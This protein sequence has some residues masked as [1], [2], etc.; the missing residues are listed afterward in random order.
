MLPAALVLSLGVPVSL[1]AQAPGEVQAVAQAPA[2]QGSVWPSVIF[3]G[4]FK[5]SPDDRTHYLERYGVREGL[6]SDRRQSWFGDAGDLSLVYHDGLRD[7]VRIQRHVSSRY[8]QRGTARVDTSHIRVT[9]GYGYFQ[10]AASGLDYLFAPSQIEGAVDPRYTGGNVGYLGKFNDAVRDPLFAATRTTYNG[11]LTVKPAAFADKATVGVA[12]HGID[13]S[14]TAFSSL[15]TGGGDV[16]GTD[17]DRR[18]KLRWNGY[19]SIVD[20]STNELVF[21]AAVRPVKQLNMEYELGYER[22]RN[23]APAVDLGDVITASGIRIVSTTAEA[24]AEEP[25]RQRPQPCRHTSC[26]TATWSVSRSRRRPV[27][28]ACC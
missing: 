18:A 14:G 22:F 21:T 24:G 27:T 8:N 28:T 2:V 1:A 4:L 19:E 16:L 7:V 6:G 12:F 20:E 3:S 11:A 10:Q 13:R 17:A 26:P 15:T 25:W 9:G 5:G 23:D